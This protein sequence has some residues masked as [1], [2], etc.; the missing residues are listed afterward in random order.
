[1]NHSILFFFRGGISFFCAHPSLKNHDDNM[2]RP[3]FAYFTYDGK[4]T[5]N[6]EIKEEERK[7]RKGNLNRLF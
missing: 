1:M 5:Y 6:S 2:T 7:K 4:N 3:F